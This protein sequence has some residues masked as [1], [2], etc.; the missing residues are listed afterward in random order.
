M[1]NIGKDDTWF[2]NSIKFVHTGHLY[3][4]VN[5][6]RECV[7]DKSRYDAFCPLWPVAVL[8]L[9]SMFRGFTLVFLELGLNSEDICWSHFN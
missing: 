4:L 7:F 2:S 1:G 8:E 6:R 9:Q 5:I 3:I